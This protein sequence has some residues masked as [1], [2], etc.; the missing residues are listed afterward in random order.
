MAEHVESIEKQAEANVRK[1]LFGEHVRHRLV[2]GKVGPFI[3]VSRETGAGGSEIARMVGRKL[4]WDIL[5][6]EIVDYLASEFGTPRSL[7]EL[8]DEKEISWI[9]DIFTSWIEG[10]GIASSAYVHR[11]HELILLAAHHGNVVLVGRGARFILPRE[12]GLSVR[13]LAPLDFRVERVVMLRGLSVKEARE[14]VDESDHEREAF[15]K[16]YFHHS[17][18][19]PHMYDLV[20]NVEKMVQEDAADLIVGATRS[21]MKNSGV[22]ITAS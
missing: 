3:A 21:W 22:T 19:D 16:E 10:L 17:S 12:R 8:A 9:Q 15:V 6:K 11:L 2:S 7:I 5:D 20:I 13:I 14:F 1:W 18:T 4:G